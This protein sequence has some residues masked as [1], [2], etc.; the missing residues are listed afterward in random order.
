M[1][2]TVNDKYPEEVQ[3]TFQLPNKTES[4]KTTWTLECKP[5]SHAKR[6]KHIKWY[7]NEKPLASSSK[8]CAHSSISSSSVMLH[9]LLKMTN[10]AIFT[11]WMVEHSTDRGPWVDSFAILAHA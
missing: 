6:T 1:E 4:A 10:I 3:Y 9:S 11:F 5:D 7:R 2:L 8:V